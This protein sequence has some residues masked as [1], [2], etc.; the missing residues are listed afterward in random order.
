MLI[1][2]KH[3]YTFYPFD[4]QNFRMINFLRFCSDVTLDLRVS[5]N[6]VLAEENKCLTLCCKAMALFL[7][8]FIFLHLFE[9]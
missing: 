6:F 3:T 2:I 5:F 4:L 1:D 9:L 8:G 7:Q